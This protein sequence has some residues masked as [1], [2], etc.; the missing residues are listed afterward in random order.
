MTE[1]K[2]WLLIFMGSI[3]RSIC[4]HFHF[5]GCW[6]W[7]N[8]HFCE[9]AFIEKIVQQKPPTYSKDF[10]ML[11]SLIFS[12]SCTV[13]LSFR[14]FQHDGLLTNLSKWCWIPQRS[15]K[16][17]SCLCSMF[18]FHVLLKSSVRKRVLWLEV[19]RWIFKIK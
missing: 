2:Q 15:G 18:F 9:Y 6:L 19:F 8:A 12:H 13:L 5:L 16:S 7:S 3:I 10:F 14:Y 11:V 4:N 17:S 1:V